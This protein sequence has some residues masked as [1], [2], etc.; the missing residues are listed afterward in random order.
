MEEN[1]VRNSSIVDVICLLMDR[2]VCPS[3]AY[4]KR[5][6]HFADEFEVSNEVKMQ[7]KNY[8][9]ILSPSE[10]MFEYLRWT[11]G[12]LTIQTIKDY[13]GKLERNDVVDKLNETAGISGRWIANCNKED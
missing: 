10:A 12:S 5:W 4:V 3:D 1:I 8:T 13:L 11:H 2:S 6:E 7:C 9:G